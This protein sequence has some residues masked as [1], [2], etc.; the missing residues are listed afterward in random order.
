MR[1]ITV[2]TLTLAGMMYLSACSKKLDDIQPDTQITFDQLNKENLPLVVNGAKLS[3]SNNNAF[4]LYYAFQDMMSDDVETLTYPSFDRNNV[5]PN[6]ANLS[7]AYRQP[8]QCIANANMVIRYAELHAEDASLKASAGEAYL[9]RAYAYL[10]LT[11]QFGSTAIIYGTEDPKGRPARNP[12]AEV[13]ALAEADLKKAMDNLPG[14]TNPDAGSREAAQLLLA[15]LYLNRGRHE[16]AL[17]MVNAVISSGRFTLQSGFADIFKSKANS[18]EAMYRITETTSNND[19]RLGLPQIYGPGKNGGPDKAG[20][21]NTWIDSMLVRSYESTD[22]R[23]AM[24]IYV[25]GASVMENLYY[26]VKFPQETTP[27]YVLCRYAEAF[28]IKAEATARK[29][30]VD[31]TAYNQLRAARKASLRNNSDFATPQAFLDEIEQERRR[32][33]VGERMRWND[34]RRF[35]KAAA[36]LQAMQQPATHVLLPVP[37]RENF[38]NPALGQNPDY[39]N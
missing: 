19:I 5:S 7:P 32:E 2:Y 21:G 4:Y 10:M 18:P 37:S 24:F 23:K 28:L 1:K 38:I 27:S 36:W 9:L 22:V 39:S 17:T 31:V 33:F 13:Y 3:L 6:D 8:Y 11:E 16:E 29:G 12:E 35:G 26:L 14:Y 25:K 20:N 34:M 15:R 30:V